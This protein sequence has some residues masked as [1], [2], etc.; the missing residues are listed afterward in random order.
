MLVL[1]GAIKK[2][3]TS[4]FYKE[5]ALSWIEYNEEGYKLEENERRIWE[6]I[7]AKKIKP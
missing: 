5:D 6:K 3:C 2:G 7:T 1:K 4:F